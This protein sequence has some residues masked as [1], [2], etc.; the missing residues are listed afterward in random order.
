VEYWKADA[1]QSL[2]TNDD[3]PSLFGRVLEGPMSGH[4]NW[5]MPVHYDL[6]AWVAE[7]NPSGVF[8]PFNS[9][10]A[11]PS[12]AARTLP[13]DTA[14]GFWPHETGTAVGTSETFEHVREDGS[15]YDP[16]LGRRVSPR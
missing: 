6:H 1:D 10:L 2:G 3:R 9:A 14:V 11:C 16:S 5:G 15:Y 13:G 7:E 4:G 8:A 12:A